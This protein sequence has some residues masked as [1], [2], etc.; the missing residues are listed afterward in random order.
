MKETSLNDIRLRCGDTI[1][2]KYKFRDGRED[3]V[4][5]VFIGYCGKQIQC[6][7]HN[8]LGYKYYYKNSIVEIL[9]W[10]AID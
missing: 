3:I 2:F 1:R 9:E 8:M 4:S 5:A 6:T 7:N 10:K